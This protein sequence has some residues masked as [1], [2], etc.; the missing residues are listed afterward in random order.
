MKIS[1]VT[2]FNEAQNIEE[3]YLEIK[4]NVKISVTMNIL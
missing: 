2:T 3:L 4:R 1:I